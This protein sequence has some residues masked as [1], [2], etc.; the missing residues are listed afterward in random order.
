MDSGVDS[1]LFYLTPW[2][3]VSPLCRSKIL[4]MIKVLVYEF[5]TQALA[6]KLVK[7][8]DGMQ[9]YAGQN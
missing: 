3:D 4:I 1:S 6:S 8:E 9:H 5:L 7:A 2:L